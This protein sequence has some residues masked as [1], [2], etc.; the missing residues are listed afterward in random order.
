MITKSSGFTLIE[1]LVVVAI[2]GIIAAIGIVSYNGYVASAKKTSA[3]N[4]M[5]QISLGQTEYYSDNGSY[6][7]PKNS[8]SCSPSDSTS[9]AI[10]T[11]LLGGSDSITE[12]VGYNICV[13]TDGSKYKI[14]AKEVGGTCEL[15]L[16]ANGRFSP[17]DGKN[18]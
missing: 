10:E 11:E 4:I 14:F 2:L 6:Y 8:S 16:L 1:L 9:N 5:Q 13:A 15:T 3:K 7:M 18:C 17:P 12:E